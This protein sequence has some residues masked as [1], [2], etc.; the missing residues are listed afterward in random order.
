MAGLGATSRRRGGRATW[1]AMIAVRARAGFA[2]LGRGSLRAAR[3]WP[4]VLCALLIVAVWRQLGHANYF[5]LAQFD[6]Q[7]GPHVAKAELQ[8][9]LTARLG[10]NIFTIDLK[11][12]AQRL[13]A[14]P[15]IKSAVIRRELP[16]ALR[17]EIVER[18]AAAVLRLEQAYLV[19][20]DGVVFK[21][22][23]RG[24]PVDLPALTGFSG[25]AFEQGGEMAERQ[26][27]KIAEAVHL[28]Q[29]CQKTAVIRETEISEIGY[30]LVTGFTL[31]TA[32][33]A[34]VVR[35]GEGD[36]ERKLRNFG[37]L[38]QS[39]K[40][41]MAQVKAVDLETPGR[42]VVRGLRKGTDA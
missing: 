26:A 20:E 36:Y 1:R 37:L 10:Q 17:V 33:S 32:D 27:R 29:L 9:F 42:V 34:M 11:F 28:M 16:S 15:W 3:L 41:G 12:L 14:Y 24:D 6:I 22:I 7:T 40:Q 35:F 30:D 25:E 2:W 5:R 8:S 39:L 31:I 38:A 21:R 18:Q 4:A 19:D 13:K 23:D